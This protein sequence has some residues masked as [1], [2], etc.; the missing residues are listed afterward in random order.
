MVRRRARP[1]PHRIAHQQVTNVNAPPA[2]GG[3]TRR[4][5]TL[6]FIVVGMVAFW[7]ALV[8]AFD[9]LLNPLP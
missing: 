4:L 3:I 7:A 1:A 6:G 9:W 5:S 8:S 2:D